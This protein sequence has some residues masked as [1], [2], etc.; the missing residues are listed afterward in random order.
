MIPVNRPTPPPPPHKPLRGRQI[1]C[2][3]YRYITAWGKL[4][5]VTID[6]FKQSFGK[7]NR[8]V[9]HYNMGYKRRVAIAIP[10]PGGLIS[11]I[12]TVILSSLLYTGCILP[13]GMLLSDHRN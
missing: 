3:V 4:Q 12:R 10:A 1:I 11:K 5:V 7:K 8:W 13:A 2:V 9:A 6:T